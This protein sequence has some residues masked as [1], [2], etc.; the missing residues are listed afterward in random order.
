[1]AICQVVVA[2][3]TNVPANVS[4]P[5]VSF[6][7]GAFGGGAKTRLGHMGIIKSLASHGFI[8]ALLKNCNVGC[9]EG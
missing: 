1:M 3:P 8:I 7:H 9:A 6:A 4:L 5:F 2:Y